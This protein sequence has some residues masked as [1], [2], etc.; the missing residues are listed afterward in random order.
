MALARRGRLDP[1]PATSTEIEFGD[2][3]DSGDAFTWT[4]H[5]WK[6]NWKTAKGQSGFYWRIGICLDDGRRPLHR[7][8]A[9]VG[10]APLLR[11]PRRVVPKNPLGSPTHP[12]HLIEDPPASFHLNRPYTGLAG[13]L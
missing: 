3:A 7:P 4:G 6:Y 10:R 1:I 12:G 2:P 11:T 8:E 13:G 5:T 9:D